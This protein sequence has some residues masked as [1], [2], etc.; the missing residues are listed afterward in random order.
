MELL[1]RF[2]AIARDAGFDLP[3]PLAQWYRT[4][5]AGNHTG[6]AMDGVYDFEW[7]TPDASEREIEEWLNPDAQQGIRFFPFA[8]SGG[9]DFY[10]LVRLADGREG[11]ACIWHD[12]ENSQI[13]YANFADFVAASYLQSYADLSHLGDDESAIADTIR[14]GLACSTPAL[15][16]AHAEALLVPAQNAVVARAYQ[17]GPRARPIQVPALL[18]QEDAEA[19][20]ASFT[21]KEP[22]VFAVVPSWEVDD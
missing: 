13:D 21:L 17:S 2:T 8:Q 19:R 22:L 12:D 7:L 5:S 15:P 6:K 20:A 4:D 1:E 10:A 9:G 16:P 14:A 18:A 3:A 11:V